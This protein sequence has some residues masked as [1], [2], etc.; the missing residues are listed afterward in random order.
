MQEKRNF[1]AAYLGIS[2]GSSSYTRDN[3]ASYLA[4]ANVNTKKFACLIGDDIYALTHSVFHE[5]P[6]IKSLRR[7][8]SMGDD[9]ASMIERISSRVGTNIEIYRWRD[10]HTRKP[11]RDIVRKV[12]EHYLSSNDFSAVVR[13]EVEGNLSTRLKRIRSTSSSIDEKLMNRLDSYVLHEIAGL[14]VMSEYLGFPIEVY[15]GKDVEVVKAIYNGDFP[16]LKKI[17]PSNTKRS[18]FSLN[19]E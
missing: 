16:V 10:L 14:I 12:R 19:F 13:Y 4:W 17:L 2:L 18:F 6:L 8:R 7:A 3:F 9:V 1:D 11:Y 15:P 5:Y